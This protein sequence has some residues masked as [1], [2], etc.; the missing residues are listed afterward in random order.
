M[1]KG[2]PTL[3]EVRGRPGET[4]GTLKVAGQNFACALGK[5]G[6][7]AAK[8]EGDGGTPEGRFPLR[9]LRY[10]ADR[11]AAPLTGLLTYPLAV[12]DGWCDEPGDPAYN[13]LVKLPYP[14]SHETLTRDD[15]LYDALVVIGYN[16]APARTGLG[17][18]IFLHVAKKAGG[19]FEPTA[20]CVA[21]PIDD[22]HKVLAVC[23][24]GT[25]IDIRLI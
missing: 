5:S 11:I 18:A 24:P 19:A 1:A 4:Q 10:R 8:R 22:L 25:E 17:S 3:I 16:D 15:H 2:D 7:V 20:G 9:E 6:I 23:G 14:A 12:T 21:L 13:R